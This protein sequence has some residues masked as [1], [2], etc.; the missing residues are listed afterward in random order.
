M[1]TRSS[2]SR[3]SLCD[4]RR[5]APAGFDLQAA[6]AL[7]R[8]AGLD[9]QP[10]EVLRDDPV[11]VLPLFDGGARDAGLQVLPM[12]VLEGPD[13]VH[14]VGPAER[15][16]EIVRCL[17]ADQ[18]PFEFGLVVGQSVLGRTSA[19]RGSRGLKSRSARRS[20]RWTWDGSG[21][22][23]EPR[24]T[25]ASPKITRSCSAAAPVAGSSAT[26]SSSATVGRQDMTKRL[27][28]RASR[29]PVR[30]PRET[31][32]SPFRE[33]TL[34]PDQERPSGRYPVRVIVR[35]DLIRP[36]E[37]DDVAASDKAALPGAQRRRRV[38]TRHARPVEH[39]FEFFEQVVPVELP[40][41]SASAS[42]TTW[43]ANSTFAAATAFRSSKPWP[44]S[45]VCSLGNRLR[46]AAGSE[47]GYTW[48]TRSRNGAGLPASSHRGESLR[49]IDTPRQPRHTGYDRGQ[50]LQLPWRKPGHQDVR[51]LA[52]HHFLPLA[53]RS[54]RAGSYAPPAPRAVHARHS[55]KASAGGASTLVVA[56]HEEHPRRQ[57]RRQWRQCGARQRRASSAYTLGVVQAE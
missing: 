11:H 42:P 34:G 13:A 9:Q 27:S 7:Q 23:S 12:V 55:R 57:G 15:Q 44:L 38:E 45:Q 39:V 19:A 8:D 18:Q 50:G 24:T 6:T 53:P 52:R 31:G 5:E 35:C 2:G 40:W 26:A 20:R 14:L 36:T 17:P 1:S 49:R 29:M 16:D 43:Y 56:V 10:D 28:K 22:T 37:P 25:C 32:A 4:D 3:P 21:S 51:L 47:Y 48:C 46:L 54:A 41:M 30:R 33:E